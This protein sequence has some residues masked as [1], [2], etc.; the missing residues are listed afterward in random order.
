MK[1]II[2]ILFLCFCSSAF[3]TQLRM[4]MIKQVVYLVEGTAEPKL[5][6]IEVPFVTAYAAPESLVLAVAK[7]LEP[8]KDDSWQNPE[9][10]NVAVAYGVKLRG[11]YGEGNSK[12]IVTVDA[13]EA[14]IP[15]NLYPFTVTE[16]CDAISQC[17]KEMWKGYG[18]SFGVLEIK[19]L[20]LEKQKPKK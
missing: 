11:E 8:L 18:D 7:P 13:S 12:F 2:L 19:V 16:V 20:G 14:K 10:I 4:E 1:K 5:Q 3:A 9:N 17:L 15:N 6:I